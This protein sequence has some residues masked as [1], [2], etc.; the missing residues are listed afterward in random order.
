MKSPERP[1][2]VRDTNARMLTREFSSQFIA[3]VER[4]A[5]RIAATE[6]DR[7]V[8]DNTLRWEIAAVAQSRRAATRTV[9]MVS[10]LDTWAFAVQ[11]KAFVS[12][13][14]AGGELF[15]THQTAVR[16][17][18]DD[19]A[20]A[21]EALA[22][23]LV[24]A[25]EFDRYQRFV[26]AYAQDHPLEDLQFARPSVLE[27]WSRESGTNTKLVDSLGT[28]PEAMSDVAERLKIYGDTVPSQVM[29]ETQ[30]ALRESGYEKGSVQSAVKELNER[31]ERLT[32][33]AEHAPSLVQSATA[34]VRRSVLEVIERLTA[35]SAATTQALRA[36]RL[37]LSATVDSE[38]VAVMNA[39]DLERQAIASDASRIANEVVKT[40]GEQAR[41]LVREILLWLSVLALVVLGLPFA[42][43]YAVGRAR[44]SARS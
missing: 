16:A 9:P 44:R 30:L 21:A 43:G 25:G 32:S 40:S 34:D 27:L 41:Y 6:Q 10:L 29:W 23:R 15:G 4:S 26:T 11:L 28:I 14:G 22:R 33:V 7:T 2:S 5:Q 12:Q 19:S 1:L 35:S 36:E 17:I 31:L 20:D 3:T 24:P 42:A 8:L 39:A 18:A 13:M 37:A 38:R